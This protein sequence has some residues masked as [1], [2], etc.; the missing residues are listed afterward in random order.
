MAESTGNVAMG[1]TR[2]NAQ[3]VIM[4]HDNSLSQTVDGSSMAEES[5]HGSTHHNGAPT[6]PLVLNPQHVRVTTE[7]ATGSSRHLYDGECTDPASVDIEDAAAGSETT[8]VAESPDQST[9]EEGAEEQKPNTDL[10]LLD[11]N[12]AREGRYST[13]M[14]DLNDIDITDEQHI[15]AQNEP[16]K[17]D[18]LK[19]SLPDT[20][21]ADDVVFEEDNS[22][23][24][25]STPASTTTAV[26][27]SVTQAHDIHVGSEDVPRSELLEAVTAAQEAIASNT[28][29]NPDEA[30]ALNEEVSQS[31]QDI[32]PLLRVDGDDD[33]N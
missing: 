23:V 9:S 2:S 8:L 7:V 22:L 3:A 30:S 25:V 6:A 16:D 20:D 26:S 5:E 11:E 12:T 10:A 1:V 21:A 24:T 4:L 14:S 15:I 32:H 29:I 19:D 33:D 18:T 13:Q 27:V 28:E 17:Q 31:S